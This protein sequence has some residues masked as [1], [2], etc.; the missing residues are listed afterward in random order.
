[1]HASLKVLKSLKPKLLQVLAIPAL[2]LGTFLLTGLLMT[3]TGSALSA[4]IV[5]LVILI[6]AIPWLALPFDD[7]PG[8]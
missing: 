6:T 7:A 4:L 8:C 3:V 1:M 2:V 5:A